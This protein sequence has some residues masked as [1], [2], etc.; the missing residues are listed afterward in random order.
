MS[1]ELLMPFIGTNDD[2][3]FVHGF[4][5]GQV[6]TLMKN[7][8]K[9]DNYIIHSCNIPQIEMMCRHFYYEYRIENIDETWSALHGSQLAF[10]N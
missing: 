5:C 3:K 6:W 2:P 8:T 1:N 9:F 4:E 7:K 10:I